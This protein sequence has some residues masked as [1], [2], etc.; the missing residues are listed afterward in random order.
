VLDRFIIPDDR[1]LLKAARGAASA[2]VSAIQLRDKYG[3]FGG[4]LR[5]AKKIKRICGRY[6]VPFI[7]NDRIDIA[8]A[9][10]ADGLHI[11]RSD[12]SLSLA[13][14]LLG[15][16]KILGVSAGSL[17]EAARARREGADYIG[18]G[19]V[20]PTP[21][22]KGKKP[23]KRSV[24][25]AMKDMNVPIIVIG[26]INLKNVAGLVGDGFRRVAVIRA[27]LRSRSPYK[28]VKRLREVI[29]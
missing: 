18:A 23:I 27:V 1:K 12:I 16:A 9:S 11:G 10:G 24:L 14:R 15:K 29:G 2:G 21:V 5:L 3:A 26:G 25:R 22:K 20:F 7:V 28:A 8:L 17:K 4:S 19:P 6:H 13:R